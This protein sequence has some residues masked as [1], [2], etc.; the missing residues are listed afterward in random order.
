[1]IYSVVGDTLF[2]VFYSCWLHFSGEILFL[3]FF[4]LYYLLLIL[5]L[6]LFLVLI[7]WVEFS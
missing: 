7:K 2:L 5:Y 3:T 1:M 4:F 6:L